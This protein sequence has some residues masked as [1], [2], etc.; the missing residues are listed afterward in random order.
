MLPKYKV[1]YAIPF[2]GHDQPHHYLTDDPVTCEAF[3]V[4]LLERGFKIHQV[5]HEGAALPKAD[6]DRLI[7]TAAG[8]LSNHLICRSLGIDKAEAHHRFG[9]PA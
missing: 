1:E 4:Q 5:L 2:H 9:T 8:I 6:F 3:L 7:R